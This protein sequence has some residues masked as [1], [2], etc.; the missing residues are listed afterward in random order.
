M[1]NHRLA[2]LLL[3]LGLAAAPAVRAADTINIAAA[4]DLIFCIQELN[5]GFAKQHPEAELKVSTGASGTFFAQ[6]KN[7][8][9]FDVFLSA[10]IQFPEA[11]VKAGLADASSLTPYAVGHLVLWTTRA[12]LDV[13]QGWAILKA[14][15]VKKLAIANPDHAPYGRAAKAAL[16]KAHLWEVLQPK[17]VFGENIAATA[18]YVETG[19]VDAGL[20]ALS[21]VLSLKTAPSSKYWELPADSYPQLDQ[22]AVLTQRGARNPLAKLYLEYLRSPEARKVF[23]HF[24]FRRPA[25]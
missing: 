14:P 18:K 24:G 3:A 19:N 16:E 10:D 2:A 9:P 8:A 1:K 5:Q 22:A 7:G 6:I 13:S 15:E 11:L 23:D 4:A 20:V 12:N 21:I 17:I 25:S